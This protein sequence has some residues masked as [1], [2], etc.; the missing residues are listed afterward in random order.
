MPGIDYL[1]AI[2]NLSANRKYRDYTKEDSWLKPEPLAS[3]AIPTCFIGFYLGK[4]RRT[5]LK[6]LCR[7]E[8]NGLVERE[9]YASLHGK[10]SA[11]KL[12][13]S[14]R[15]MQK[16]ALEFFTDGYARTGRDVFGFDRS[17]FDKFGID[18]TGFDSAGN[19]RGFDH[20]KDTYNK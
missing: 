14:G 15:A 10:G 17:G 16:S 5:V 3:G 4:N 19:Y 18:R 9:Y 7:L 12:T 2:R 20:L 1:H 13:P 6:T 11:W 8:E